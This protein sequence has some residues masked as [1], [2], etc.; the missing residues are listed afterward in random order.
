MSNVTKR[1]WSVQRWA[2]QVLFATSLLAGVQVHA[3]EAS[4]TLVELRTDLGTMVFV[5]YNETPRHRDRFLELVSSGA[6][7]G[8]LLHRVMPGFMVLGGQRKAEDAGPQDTEPERGDGTLDAEIVPG[9]IHKRGALGAVREGERTNPQRRSQGMEF[10]VVDGRSVLPDE[11]DRI[12]ERAARHGDTLHYTPEH[13]STYERLGGTPQLDGAYTIFGELVSG[14]E[15]L[16]AIV[17]VKRDEQDR[18]LQE[19]R[20]TTQLVP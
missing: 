15:V 13:R 3:Q 17:A 2:L 10:Y 4:R 8:T 16:D 12:A 19:I 6:Y 14:F 7:N 9:F 1:R 11:L 18:P 5:L 20:M